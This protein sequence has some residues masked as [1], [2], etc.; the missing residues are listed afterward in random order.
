[1]QRRLARCL[2]FVAIALLTAP[3]ALGHGGRIAFDSWGAF[4]PDDASCQWVIG[5]AA[6]MCATQSWA[7]RN[8]C[9]AAQVRGETCDTD[10][11]DARV[12]AARRAALDAVDAQCTEREAADIGYFGIFDLETDLIDYCRSWELA[13][14]SGVYDLAS[15]A[16]ELDDTEKSCLLETARSTTAVMSAVFR[17]ECAT[18]DH[19]SAGQ[20][21]TERRNHLVDQAAARVAHA[22]DTVVAHLSARCSDADFQHLYGRS[23]GDLIGA[24]AQRAACIGG[25]VYIQDRVLCPAAVCG[26]GVRE[27]TEFCDDG[28]QDP[29]DGCDCSPP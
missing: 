13:A 10:A 22:T 24:L 18:M 8:Q 16:G 3:A 21:S 7:A 14:T 2:P 20:L 27:P 26:N 19:I 25:S 12:S 15:A 11:A 28:N 6:S 17:I 9:R 29:N 4:N 1:M 5:R 23:A